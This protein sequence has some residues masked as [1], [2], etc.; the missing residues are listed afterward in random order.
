MVTLE[1]VSNDPY[2]VAYGYAEIKHIANEAR[3]IPLDWISPSRNDI[4]QPLIDYL[5]PLIVGEMPIT[6]QNGLPV[7]MDV[8]H[9]SKH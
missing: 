4:E 1:R 2:E 9:L 8:S 5:A 3:S 6:Y 7:Y